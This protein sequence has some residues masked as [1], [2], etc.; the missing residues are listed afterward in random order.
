MRACAGVNPARP[1]SWES[2]A[3]YSQNAGI[4]PI[5]LARAAKAR[6]ASITGAAVADGEALWALAHAANAAA[7]T[8][9]L[10]R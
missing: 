2:L 1:M 6:S 7:K 3:L 9:I 5:S 10:M 4:Q 8:I